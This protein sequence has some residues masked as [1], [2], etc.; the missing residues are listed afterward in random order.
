MQDRRFRAVW[1]TILVV[2]VISASAGFSPIGVIQFAQ[3]AN[4]LLLP[5]MAGLLWWL[6]S[7]KEVMGEHVNLR[8]VRVIGALVILVTL[9]LAGRSLWSVFVV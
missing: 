5:T 8:K 3:V 7:S 4:G 6:T 9:M 2:G 1:I